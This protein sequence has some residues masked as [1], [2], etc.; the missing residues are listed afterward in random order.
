M[1]KLVILNSKLENLK[2]LHLVTSNLELL[3]EQ[4]QDKLRR[5]IRLDIAY[6][7]LR[8]MRVPGYCLL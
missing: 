3:I 2:L 1:L 6:N 4:L 5:N 7:S 8:N